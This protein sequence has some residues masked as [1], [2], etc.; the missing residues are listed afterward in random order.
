MTKEGRIQGVSPKEYKGISYRSTL[1]AET[2][3]VLDLL[4]LPFEYETK[5]YVLLGKFKCPYQKDVVRAITYTPD[6][7][8]GSIIIEC[9]GFET[10]EWRN[11]KKYVYKYLMENEPETSFY[12]IKNKR[13]LLQ[14]LDKRWTELGYAVQVVNKQNRR[15]PV[16]ET[17]VF[18]S[19]EKAMHELNIGNKATG[20]ILNTMIGKKDYAYGYSWKLIKITL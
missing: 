20:T 4:G 10:P 8:M 14:A 1:E 13:S 12:Q 2:A 6:F 18:E 5:K 3:E 7:I 15:H 17:R 9:K 16:K 19:V 11:K